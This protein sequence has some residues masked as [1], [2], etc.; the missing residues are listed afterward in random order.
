MHV[1]FQG[2]GVYSNLNHHAWLLHLPSSSSFEGGQ[3]APGCRPRLQTGGVFH[4]PYRIS[5]FVILAL[6]S[7]ASLTF[8]KSFGLDL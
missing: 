5:C 4:V 3:P 8:T 7:T 2:D 1:F 6:S